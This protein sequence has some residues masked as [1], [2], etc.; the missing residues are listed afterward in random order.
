MYA[1]LG[2]MLVRH[3]NIDLFSDQTIFSL[4]KEKRESE[5]KLNVQVSV[6]E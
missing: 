3:Q 6:S 2:A 5:C 4:Q 1:A